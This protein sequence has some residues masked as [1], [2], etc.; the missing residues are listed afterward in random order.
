MKRFSVLLLCMFSMFVSFSQVLKEP[1]LKRFGDTNSGYFLAVDGFDEIWKSTINIEAITN[2]QRK[3]E[4]LSKTEE[5][6]RKEIESLQKRVEE[7]KRMENQQKRE[8]ERLQ[9]ANE[10][11][12]REINSLQDLIKNLS[13][14]IED[15]ERKI[16]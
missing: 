7:L 15:I 8:N 5:Q 3:V 14:K 9:K 13:R 6:Q 2:L 16:R 11:L 4:G 1:K 12:Q 10:K